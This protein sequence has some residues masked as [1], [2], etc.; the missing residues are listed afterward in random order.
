MRK[1]L[2]LLAIAVAIGLILL[3]YILPYT[4]GTKTN[5]I[6]ITPI[7]RIYKDG[8]LFYEKKGD[9]PTNMLVHLFMFMIAPRYTTDGSATVFNIISI[10]GNSWSF[11][12]GI[13]VVDEHTAWVI[14]GT[15][16]NP[17][18]YTDTSMEIV[19]FGEA[20]LANYYFDSTN[21]E[22]V[23]Q[24]SGS[25][26]FDGSYNITEV[27]L[28]VDV[29]DKLSGKI[30]SPGSAPAR[31]ILVFRDLLP[32]PITVSNGDSITVQYELRIKLP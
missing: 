26:L 16:T 21:K 20:R 14:A 19:G 5:T 31:N 2:S 22:W 3:P 1:T 9:P 23:I 11:N 18:A 7:M 15:G 10:N 30:D 8:V 12:P 28:T 17:P 6:T 27:G 4:D 24:I 32:S 29:A 13:E 25:I